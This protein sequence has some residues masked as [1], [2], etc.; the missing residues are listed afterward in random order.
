MSS[1]SSK[2]QEAG[3][4]GSPEAFYRL[5]LERRIKLVL[6]ATAEAGADAIVS[7]DRH[8]LALGSWHGISIET[9]VSF[10]ADLPE[11][12]RS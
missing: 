7:G 5:A 12:R 9:P 4:G 10:L 8:L 6:E 11:E 2:R 3:E 1:G